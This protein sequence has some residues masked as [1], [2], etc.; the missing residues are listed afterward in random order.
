[1]DY[2]ARM[3]DAQL[4]RWH[5]VD[6]LADSA[7]G[8]TPYRYGFNNPISFTDPTGMFESRKEARQYRREHDL[9]GTISKGK[10]G[11]FSINDTKGSTSYFKD[12]SG[13]S[14]ST[15][16][17]DGVTTAALVTG[18]NEGEKS[19]NWVSGL[20]TAATAFDTGNSI[21]TELLDYAVRN[22]FKSN[23]TREGWEKLTERQ[24]EWRLKRTLGKTGVKYLKGAKM[25]SKAAGV[26]GVGVTVYQAGSD[27]ADGRY[28]S[29]GTRVAVAGVAAGAAFIPV[30]GWGVTIGIGVADAVWGDQFYDYV[31]NKLGN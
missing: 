27:I 24:Q 11:V 29:A 8:W 30:V 15:T 7:P 14:Y 12:N 28:Y 10:D 5:V 4:G 2:G 31:E 23:N 20:G 22:N 6:P 25:A 1:M 17:A 3:Y 26:V 13:I 19:D 9:N 16:G 21:K 18:Q